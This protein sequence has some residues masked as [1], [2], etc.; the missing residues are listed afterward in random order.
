M[1]V[2][3]AALDY[4][5]LGAAKLPASLSYGAVGDILGLLN[6][7]TR[8]LLDRT[9]DSATLPAKMDV[10]ANSI[11]L[12]FDGGVYFQY[13]SRDFEEVRAAVTDPEIAAAV[14][15]V[16]GSKSIRFWYDE[17]YVR[18]PGR[19]D[20]S[21]PWH[22]DIA[23]LP[24]K[25]EKLPSVWFAL[26]NVALGQSHFRTIDGSHLD[27]SR[28]YKP[29]TGR[30]AKPLIDGYAP[31]P[32]FEEK[33]AA[34]ECQARDWPL[35]LG[36]GVIFDPYCIHGTTANLSPKPRVSLAT[37]WIGDDVTWAPDAYSVDEPWLREPA[38]REHRLA[39][40]PDLLNAA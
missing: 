11:G 9:R 35:S 29:P 16:V 37:R 17:L 26:G 30:E 23:A 31:L 39:L 8:D 15:G 32:D 3:S 28:R 34:S 10:G 14:A 1:D 20:N 24:F 12:R 19:E 5:R 22:H 38:D 33:L 2:D 21:T 13:L 7:L 40:F 36:D 25:G 6:A 18:W 27:R 4:S